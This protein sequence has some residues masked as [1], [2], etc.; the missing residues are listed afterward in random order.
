[1]SH[2]RSCQVS[3]DTYW[4]KLSL[5]AQSFHHLLETLAAAIGFG[6]QGLDPGCYGVQGTS[7]LLSP[8]GN[9]VNS[10]TA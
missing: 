1:M 2:S 4:H 6:Q 8:L 5:K 3:F 9:K 7:Y 10:E